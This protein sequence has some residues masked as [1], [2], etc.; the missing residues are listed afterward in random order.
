MDRR[1]LDVIC[2]RLLFWITDFWKGEMDENCL[3]EHEWFHNIH[4]I[5]Y[6]IF[7]EKDAMN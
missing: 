7:I 4:V 5:G 1:Q 6:K 3:N 2:F